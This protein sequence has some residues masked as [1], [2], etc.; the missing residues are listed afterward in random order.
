MMPMKERDPS[1]KIGIINAWILDGGRK[2]G[3]K[4]EIPDTV[5]REKKRS[6]TGMEPNLT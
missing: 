1:P 6:E 5:M 4:R 2:R 3:T